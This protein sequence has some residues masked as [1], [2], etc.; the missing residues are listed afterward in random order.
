VGEGALFVEQH[1]T[2][3][4]ALPRARESRRASVAAHRLSQLGVIHKPL[5]ANGEVLPPAG[6]EAIDP[7]PRHLPCP[8]TVHHDN[9]QPAAHGLEDHVAE[10]LSDGGECEDVSLCIGV[11]EFVALQPAGGRH[12]RPTETLDLRVH[13]SLADDVEVDVVPL[14]ADLKERIQQDSDA[15]LHREAAD[16]QES[17]ATILARRVGVERARVHTVVPDIH[18]HGEHAAEPAGHAVGRHEHQVHLVVEPPHRAPCDPPPATL[19]KTH[20]QLE[21]V[22]HRGVEHAHSGQTGAACQAQAAEA[23]GGGGGNV[24]DVVVVTCELAADV[25]VRRDV[26]AQVPVVMHRD[27]AALAEDGDRAVV[28]LAGAGPVGVHVQCQARPGRVLHQV[29]IGAGN[30]IGLVEGVGE[31]SDS[32]GRSFLRLLPCRGRGP[33]APSG[34]EPVG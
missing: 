17:D 27:A 26:V 20:T 18:G 16:I 32:H 9:G 11:S 1:K 3:E 31:E 25:E 22:R 4:F 19:H 33:G 29:L 6:D 30:A 21:V 23:Q 13:G 28:L 7:V 15:L 8:A 34:E 5:Q 14:G 12:P 10:R 24:D 2:I